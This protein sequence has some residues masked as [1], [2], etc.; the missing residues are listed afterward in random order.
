MEPANYMPT[1]QRVREHVQ[2]LTHLIKS[3][4]GSAGSKLPYAGLIGAMSS[5]F[6]KKKNHS[7]I[8]KRL[9]VF[10]FDGARRELD[11]GVV[12]RGCR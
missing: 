12:G 7:E 8:V 1:R 10:V 2:E 5:M 4:V 11:S 9:F 6:G 3:T